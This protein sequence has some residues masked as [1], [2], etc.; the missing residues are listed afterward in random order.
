MCHSLGVHTLEDAK[1]INVPCG[2]GK[3][4]TDMLPALAV[5]LE[6]PERLHDTVL[7]DLACLGK[8]TRI[9]KADH[10]AVIAEQVLLVIIRVDLAY[11][12]CHE[13][14]DHALGLWGVVQHPWRER[15]AA[16]NCLTVCHCAHGKATES[17]G[18]AAQGASTGD[19][20]CAVHTSVY[21]LI[22]NVSPNLTIF[23]HGIK[24]ALVQ[25][26]EI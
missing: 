17:A 6:F 20:M 14:K 16:C 3:E 10:L 21:S 13:E 15:I 4:F 5:L 24:S 12:A 9:I 25:V 19:M 2:M 22:D 23:N 8:S 26:A 11:A 1:V 18:H 7:D